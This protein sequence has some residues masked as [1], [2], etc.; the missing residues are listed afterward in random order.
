MKIKTLHTVAITMSFVFLSCSKTTKACF[1]IKP[2]ITQ[3][4]SL[5]TFDAS[6]SQNVYLYQW[7]FGDGTSDTITNQP[8]IQHRFQQIGTFRVQLNCKRKDG[9]SNSNSL[10]NKT[11][12]IQVN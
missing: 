10:Q 11:G 1:Q 6:C 12:Y 7:N 9:F 4:D 8:I 3:K 5:V 2:E